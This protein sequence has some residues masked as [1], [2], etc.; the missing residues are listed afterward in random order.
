MSMSPEP[1][2]C[3]TRS[4]S[5]SKPTRSRAEIATASG[6]SCIHCPSVSP[7]PP[8]SKLFLCNS[9]SGSTGSASTL[10]NAI[11]VGLSL[12]PSS[13]NVSSTAL[14]CS[15]AFGCVM[16]TTC[17]RTFDS[18]ISSSVARNA[19]MS[20]VGNFSIKPTVSLNK[21]SCPLGNFTRRVV[22]SSVAKSWS[23]T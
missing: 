5:A 10:L 14:T 18:M 3:S 7:S 9:K 1:R 8:F 2:T 15:A 13:S 22:G 16:S 19:A 20:C 6:Y 23:A 21:T 17:N 4:S 11:T 12:A